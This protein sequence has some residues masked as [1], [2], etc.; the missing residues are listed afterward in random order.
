MLCKKLLAFFIL[1]ITLIYT[2]PVYSE[3]QQLSAVYSGSVYDQD[4]FLISSGSVKAYV[5]SDQAQ[6]LEQRGVLNFIDGS[7]Q[8]LI[9]QGSAGDT[10]KPVLFRV[11]AGGKEYTARTDPEEVTW[12]S[13]TSAVPVNLT[14]NPLVP[15]ASP[16]PGEYPGSVTVSLS[17]GAS[18]VKIYYT[19]DGSSPKDNPERIEYISPFTLSDST[20]IKAVSLKEQDYSGVSTF[21][22]SIVNVSPPVASPASG[23]YTGSVTVGLSSDTSGA[24]IY[25]TTDGSNPLDSQERL[26]YTTS[27]TLSK[28][29]IVK[30]VVIKNDIYSEV[31]SFEYV[32]QGTPPPPGGGGILLPAVKIN[33]SST[34]VTLDLGKVEQ[35]LVT[36][37]PEGA[38]LTFKSSDSSAVT[39]RSDGLLIATGTGTA[40]ITVTAEK[41]G[42]LPGTVSVAV[43][44][45]V[46]RPEL[47]VSPIKLKIKVGE[48]RQLSASTELYKVTLYYSSSNTRVA[49]VNSSGLVTATGKGEA[50]I[51]VTAS[52][53]SLEDT[54]E[55]PVTVS[56]NPLAI[57]VTPSSLEMKVGETNQLNATTDPPGATVSYSSSNTRVATVSPSGL[58]T[59]IGKGTAVVRATAR[60]PGCS[61]DTEEVTVNVADNPAVTSQLPANIPLEP[62]FLDVPSNYWAY[63]VIGSLNSKGIV[64]GYPNGYFKPE[65]NISRAEFIKILTRAMG[66]AEEKTGTELFTDVLSGEWY[67][68][69]INAAAKA[70]L[71][72]G[73]ESGE[74]RPNSFI[75]RQEMAVMLVR[76]LGRESEA[77]ASA[78]KNTAF[79]DDEKIAPWAKGFVMV[80]VREKLVS[81]YPNNTFRPDNFATRAEACAMVNNF[82][83]KK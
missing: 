56:E 82:L 15:A 11:L 16:A 42:F 63:N 4:G 81:G 46:V 43:S 59:A 67:C 23:I 45:R 34:D 53:F 32:I 36:T 35:L 79:A 7:Y 8:N 30:A 52:Y 69:S 80:A 73:Y 44:V 18:G 37:D 31:K 17:C 55:V 58:I 49:T 60:K 74:F 10:G 65:N 76:A 51:K 75:T 62:E 47:S 72:K 28:S 14:V 61:T 27:F 13:G 68:G 66:L 19:I 12:N 2:G 70:G 41:E 33:L 26:Q 29:T 6:K 5:Y 21:Y 50:K 20:V 1:L 39:V 9:V 77:A 38:S 54:V 22:Y 78:G 83:G 3:E 24:M 57:Y 40:T 48:T 25:Y 64:G 71:S